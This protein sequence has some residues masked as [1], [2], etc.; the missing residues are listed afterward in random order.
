MASLLEK[1]S[2]LISANLHYLVDQALKS[3]SMAVIDHYIRQLEDHL[4][5][6]EDAAATVGAQVKSINRKLLVQ[7]Q[8]ADDL[9]RAINGFLKDG[10]EIMAKSSQEKFNNTQRLATTYREQLT[11]LESEYQKL[12]ASRQKLKNR[13][14]TVKQ[15]REELQALLDLAKSKEAAVKV[16][17]SLDDLRESKDNDI[18]R[19]AQGIYARL[20][21]ATIVTEIKSTSFEEQMEHVLDQNTIAVQ[22]AERK[23]ALLENK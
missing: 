14:F 3:N 16:M 20:D 5:C 9:D 17:E 23:K 7:E 2:I 21:K 15:Q 6:M 19:I 10:K 18:S 8:K 13:L 11:H 1:V 22:L 12:L 4:E